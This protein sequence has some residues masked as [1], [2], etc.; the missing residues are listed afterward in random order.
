MFTGLIGGPHPPGGDG[1][2]GLVVWIGK[3]PVGPNDPGG[4]SGGY[5]IGAGFIGL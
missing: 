3:S 1:L 4:L 2:T 5:L